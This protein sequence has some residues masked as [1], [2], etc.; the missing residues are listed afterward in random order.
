MILILSRA[1][2][3]VQGTTETKQRRT[4]LTVQRA[5]A[6]ITTIVHTWPGNFFYRTVGMSK[7]LA[8]VRPGGSNA[9]DA[10]SFGDKSII[11]FGRSRVKHDAILP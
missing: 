8:N 4:P 2:F 6:D 7:S 5:L 10:A 9:E 11:G 3:S 1:A